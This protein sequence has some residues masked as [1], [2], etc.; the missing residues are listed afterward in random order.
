MIWIPSSVHPAPFIEADYWTWVR[1]FCAV[2]RVTNGPRAALFMPGRSEFQLLAWWL[3]TGLNQPVDRIALWMGSTPQAIRQTIQS[4]HHSASASSD[5]VLQ[6]IQIVVNDAPPVPSSH[7][8]VGMAAVWMSMHTAQ[9]PL[10]LFGFCAITRHANRWAVA[11]WMHRVA[12]VSVDHVAHRLCLTPSLAQRWI[13]AMECLGFIHRDA[14]QW[15][16]SFRG[17]NRAAARG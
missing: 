8:A 12:G 3:A 7:R 5:T 9:H 11:W 17:T 13:T 4:M 2:Q 10:D 14:E 1:G 15:M 6:A 16:Q